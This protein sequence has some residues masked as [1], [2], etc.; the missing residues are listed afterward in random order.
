MSEKK[1]ANIMLL[2]RTGVGKSSFINYLVGK[3]VSKTGTGMPVTQGFD[4]YEFNDVAGIP[5]RIFDSKGL[6]VRDYG[7]IRREIFSFV[8]KCC[9]S[10][11]IYE[12]M[13]SIFYC[14]NVDSRRVEPE[15]IDFI[16]M[17]NGKISQTVH[18][19]MTHCELSTEGRK[20]SEAMVNHI[21]SQ[22]KDEKIRI[23][24]V[25]SVESRTRVSTTPSFG[26]QEVLDQIFELLWF[27]M[28]H[29]VAKEYA[30]EFCEGLERIVRDTIFNSCDK[31]INEVSTIGF[32]SDLIY[33]KNDMMD[34]IE[35]IFDEYLEECG[36]MMEKMEEKCQATLKPLVEFCNEYGNSLGYEI[37]LCVH[38]DSFTTSVLTC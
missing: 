29:K 4:T 23:Y 13:H 24:C 6:G 27:D 22:L 16:K 35:K 14:I 28:A 32:I 21:K 37:E 25:N 2:G 19:I 30:K 38:F 20:K 3:E 18:I 17:F 11:D 33:D 31:A 34:R 12:W 15:E 26:R 1:Y 10:E 9:G 5:L 8:Q 36:V 7:Q